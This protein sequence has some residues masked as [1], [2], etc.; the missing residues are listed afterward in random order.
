MCYV[1]FGVLFVM[2]AV[3]L[4]LVQDEFVF[5]IGV[6]VEVL[7]GYDY[8]GGSGS[9][10]WDGLV[11][12]IGVGYDFQLGGVVFG[13]EGE[14]SD[15]MIV[16]CDFNIVLIGDSVCYVVDCD[17]Y[18]GVCV[19]FVV[20]FWILFY[21]KGGYINVQFKMIY[22][23]GIGIMVIMCNMFDGY[24]L[25]VGIEQKMNLFGLLGFIK[26]E[27]CYLNYCN[28]NVGLLNVDI[29]FDCYQVMVGIGVWF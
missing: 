11:Y 25:G 21:V 4:V 3:S 22:D 13:F 29:D 5:F 7:V 6:Y 20:V 24:C 16:V 28:F 12:G 23:N 17:F 9:D 14:F 27:Y 19:G 18:V 8:V 2:V 1:I 26:V 10:G 15:L